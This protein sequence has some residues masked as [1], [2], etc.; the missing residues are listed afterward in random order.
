M[1]GVVTILGKWQHTNP[2]VGGANTFLDLMFGLTP[3]DLV[4]H[5][6]AYLVLLIE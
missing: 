4:D 5:H 3:A 1:S 2:T 6:L